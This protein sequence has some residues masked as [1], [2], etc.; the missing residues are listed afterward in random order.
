MKKEYLILNDVSYKIVSSGIGVYET[1]EGIQLF[2][3]V[4]AKNDQVEQELSEIHL[5][6]NN[7]FQTGV[8]RIK[9]LAGKKYVWEEA[10]NDQGEEAGFL[11]VLEH[12]NVTQGIIEIMDVGRNE[13]TLKWKGK[14]NIFWSDSF[15]ADVPFETVLQMKLPKKRRVTIDA[16][17]TVN[18]KVNKDLEIE[19]L[20]F[21]EVESAA[22]KMQET[23]IWTDFNVTLYFKVTYKGTEY[24][25]NV[26]YTNGKNNYETFFDK[27][28]SL[29]IVHDGFGWSDFAFEF[30]FCV[31]SGS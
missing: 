12:E 10:Y 3:E 31:E 15:G 16:Y 19:L 22:Y 26:V 30:V 1:N 28:C 11:C 9:E 24:L 5:Y 27:S 18:T 20:N 25:G 13:I 6:H 23:R 4:T 29:K 8:K 17:K 2:P 21:P 14:A 7:G